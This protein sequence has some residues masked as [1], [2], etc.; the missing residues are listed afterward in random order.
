MREAQGGCTVTPA[1][2]SSLESCPGP[3][4]LL[5]VL[6]PGPTVHSPAQGPQSRGHWVRGP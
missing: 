6:F 3:P 5:P 4:Q 2:Y 1:F